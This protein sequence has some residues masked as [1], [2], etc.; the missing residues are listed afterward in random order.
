MFT[1]VASVTL[2]S[3]RKFSNLSQNSGFRKV[4]FPDAEMTICTPSRLASTSPHFTPWKIR[5]RILTIW[6]SGIYGK[7]NPGT[8]LICSE[9]TKIR[10]WL[11]VVVGSTNLRNVSSDVRPLLSSSTRT[12]TTSWCKLCRKRSRKQFE[13]KVDVLLDELK[14]RLIKVFTLLV[15]YFFICKSKAILNWCILQREISPKVPSTTMQRNNCRP[16]FS[17]RTAEKRN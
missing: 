14:S 7:T 11:R 8:L 9:Y 6:L 2:Y 12:R 1:I 3:I 10:M 5:T 13:S 4:R 17:K 16:S 15:C